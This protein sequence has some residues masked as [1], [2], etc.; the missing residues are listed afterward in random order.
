PKIYAIRGPAGVGKTTVLNMI[1]GLR[2]ADN[3][4]IKV[5]ERVLTDTQ[6][7]V[8]VKIQE[9]HLGYLFQDYQLFPNMTVFQNI[10]FMAQPSEHITALM[11]QLNISYLQKQFP[12]R[13]SGG[14]AQRV[15]LARALSRRP[16]LLLLDV[17]FSSLDDATKEES[18]RLVKRLFDEWQIP[19]IFVTHSNYEAEQFADEIITLSSVPAE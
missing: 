16:D 3:A 15:A 12:A 19:I 17:Q 9:R 2:A 11:H 1:V 5:N 13:L 4:Y 18:M 6:S 10:T 8:N 7:S 14:K